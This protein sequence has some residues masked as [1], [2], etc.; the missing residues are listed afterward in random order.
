[1]KKIVL[2][3]LSV[4]ALLVSATVYSQNQPVSFK[5]SDLL[6]EIDNVVV[7]S[8]DMAQIMNEDASDEKNG[9]MYKVARILDVN[10][11]MDNC[12]T[13]DILADG[14]KVW[15]VRIVSNGAVALKVMC[16]DF[17]IPQGAELFLYNENRRQ[18]VSVNSKDN[19]QY[20]TYYSPKMIQGD[21]LY[22]EYV[23]PASVVGTP[24]INIDALSYFYRGVDAFVGYYTQKRETG[25]G[26]SLSC[27]VNVNCPLGNDW[28]VQKKGVAE[29]FVIVGWSGGFCS[30]TLVNNTANDGTPYFLT[31]DHCGGVDGANSF[32]RWE[33]YFNFESPNCNNPTSEPDYDVVTGCSLKARPSG[34]EASGTDFLLLLLSTDEDNLEQIGAY[35]NGWDRSTETTSNAIGIHHP[36]GDIKKISS[37]T[38]ELTFDTFQ[39]GNTQNGHWRATWNATTG[40]TEG[41]S[42]GS[43]LFRGSNKLVMGT[44]SGGPSYNCSSPA[45]MLYDVYGRFDLHWENGGTSSANQLK[46]WLDPQNTNAETCSG[47][48]P[49]SGTPDPPSPS[50]INADFTGTPTTVNIGGT[51]AFRDAS[52][53]NPTSWSWSFPGG[54]PSTSTSQNP[55]V[56]YSTAGTYNVSLTVS[57]GT[58][59]DTETKNAYITVNENGDVPPPDPNGE[60][61]AAFVASSYNITIG[62]CIN[63]TDMSSGSPNSWTW[64]FQGAETVSSTQQNPTNICYNTPGSYNV[65]LYVM[66]ADGDYDSEVCEG[67]IVVSNNTSQPIADFEASITVIPVGRSIRFTNLSQNGP[68]DQ[69]AWHFEGGVPENCS[70]SVPPVIAYNQVGMFDVE[71]RCRKTTGVQDIELKENYIKVVPNS[72]ESPVANFTSNKTLVRPG[73]TVNFI[74]LSTAYPYMWSWEFEGGT[75]ATSNQPYPSVVYNTPGTYSVKLT[76]SNNIG[77]DEITKEMYIVVAD[78]DPCTE[79]P[80]ANF[81][82]TE[83]L[84]AYGDVVMFENL[85]TNNPSYSYWTFEGGSPRTSTEFSPLSGVLYATPGI[86]SVTLIVSNSCGSTSITKEN[87]VR[88]YNGHVESYCDTLSNI[89]TGDV[90]GSKSVPGTW[91]FYAG[92]NGKKIKAYADY[93]RTHTFS[94]VRGLLVPVTQAVYGTY[95][96]KVTFCVWD[97]NNGMP[98]DELGTKRINIRDLAAGQTNLIRFDG[99][100]EV[101]GPFHVGFKISYPDNNS[102]DVSDDLFVV[103][104]VTNRAYNG[105]NTM[106]VMKSGEWYSSPDLLSFNTSLPIEPVSCL[107]NDIEELEA[108]NNAIDVYPNPTSGLLNISFGNQDVNG[109]DI[110]MYDALGR[111]VSFVKVSD[112]GDYS[113]DISSYP[114]GLYIIRISTSTFVANKK[115]MLTK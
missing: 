50:T 2:F 86:Y 16:S 52:T 41:G 72:D 62:D 100:I 111:L 3:V 67:C 27:E 92:Q 43:P 73:E 97:D 85:S 88:V 44:L 87:Y 38:S 17:F 14:T 58:D 13:T 103:P 89:S 49:N 105:L 82:A 21:V 96:S 10:M 15:R 65:T 37:I 42:S 56:V 90:L 93:H 110:E 115:I 34:A 5:H 40:F 8:P 59:E 114:E 48:Y 7:A 60:L 20:G 9:E 1:M 4:A 74:D 53:G 6:S 11:N 70:D 108:E 81:S 95:D 12:G 61:T 83:R 46:P 109:Y 106:S 24:V 75:P 19:P 29:I 35:Y 69:W 23:Q 77:T 55:S 79:P 94:Q 28:Q 102:D 76:V 51:V 107:E 91:G 36:A 68:F 80:Q 64:T 104:V 84:I 18:L 66:N 32:G 54:N 78:V 26:E 22:M 39:Q 101:N 71:L 99:A 25:F 45:S 112:S 30:G 63:F 113:M 57:N 33:F 47:R 98:G 31:A